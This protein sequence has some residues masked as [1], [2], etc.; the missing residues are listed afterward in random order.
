MHAY[1]YGILV[2]VAMHPQFNTKACISL[3]THFRCTLNPYLVLYKPIANVFF[4]SFIK[5]FRMSIVSAFI[6][7]SLNR[8]SIGTTTDFFIG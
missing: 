1:K 7:S 8:I 6:F 3:Y 4:G 5:S 2:G